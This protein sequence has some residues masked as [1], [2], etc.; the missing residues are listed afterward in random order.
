MKKDENIKSYTAGELKALKT[1]SQTDLD[2]VDA[3]TDEAL[4]KI[5][6]SDPDEQDIRP[7]WTKA[8]LICL[9]VIMITLLE[10]R[11]SIPLIN[12]C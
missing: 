3:M 4:E 9:N 1:K 12:V 11:K 5:I 7:E 6:A 10:V 2:R 8:K